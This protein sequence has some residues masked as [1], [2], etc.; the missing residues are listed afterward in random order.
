[1]QAVIL[2]AGQGTRIRPLS[3]TIPKPMLPVADKPIVA[4]VA[5]AAVDA[6]ADELSFYGYGVLPDRNLSWIDDV[7]SAI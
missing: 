4:H 7:L 1:M 3:E 6:G 5:G 2:A